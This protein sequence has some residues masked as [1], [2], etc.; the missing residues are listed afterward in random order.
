MDRLRSSGKRT[1]LRDIADNPSIRKPTLVQI[2]TRSI[3]V[4]EK[5][6]GQ[7][8]VASPC[9]VANNQFDK[10]EQEIIL[11]SKQSGI[12]KI[13]TNDNNHT[14][15]LATTDIED[16]HTHDVEKKRV[17]PRSYICTKQIEAFELHVRKN[18]DTVFNGYRIDRKRIYIDENTEFQ[19]TDIGEVEYTPSEGERTSQDYIV[20]SKSKSSSFIQLLLPHVQGTKNLIRNRALRSLHCTIINDP[21]KRSF[22]LEVNDQRY[23]IYPVASEGSTDLR[24]LH[25]THNLFNYLS[26]FGNDQSL[27]VKLIKGDRPA[28]SIAFDGYMTFK[29][30]LS[31]DKIPLCR[32]DNLEVTLVNLDLAIPVKVQSHDQ[33][34]NIHAAEYRCMQLTIS[35]LSR[36]ESEIYVSIDMDQNPA[37][38]LFKEQASKFCSQDDL[39]LE[40]RRKTSH[41]RGS[42]T[43]TLSRVNRHDDKH[44]SKFNR[45][46][47][48][49]EFQSI[50]TAQKIVP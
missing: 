4:G 15:R 50:S 18:D 8:I 20:V 12:W 2:G 34:P 46:H 24:Y 41:H 43:P 42:Q 21:Q 28:K 10:S 36:H 19:I 37:N 23:D 25:S 40:Q 6:H 39:R 9:R 35:L 5:I 48:K 16:I 32:V 29:R 17:T 13:V 49:Q 27:C 14:Q 38:F 44:L 3:V 30:I 7:Y 45:E 33:S 47:I 11:S 26:K 1:T 22:L 31:G